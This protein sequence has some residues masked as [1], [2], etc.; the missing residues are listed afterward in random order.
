MD[1]FDYREKL[2]VG[3][4]DEEK[5]YYFSQKIFNHL[6][7]QAV[8]RGPTGFLSFEEYFS[9]CNLIG[10]EI[11]VSLKDN[12]RGLERYTVCIKTIKNHSTDLRNFLAY[13]IAFT[14]SKKLKA[15]SERELT[16][17]DFAMLLVRVMREA[18]IQFDLIEEQNEYFIFPKG[19][20]ELDDALV[21]QPLTWLED[22]P[23]AE[24]AWIRKALEAFF[25]EFFS[26]NKALEGYKSEYGAYLKTHGVPKEISANFE[27]LLLA[28]TN[29][30]NGFAKH[31][32][33]T[34]DKVL[35]YLMY[36]TGNI[37]RLLITLEQEADH[38]D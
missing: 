10:E 23:A 29:Y 38:A 4:C 30:M 9:F 34:S 3:F 21:S 6:E 14:N 26:G 19:V 35:E 7:L 16:R 36:Q 1:W 27:T 5:F 33:A 17:K 22:Y 28:Y 31:R 13:Y 20:P 18:H 24:K 25:R 37:M 11:N 32:D 12:F 2:G 15:E 8:M